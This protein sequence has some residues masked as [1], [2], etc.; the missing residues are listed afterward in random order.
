MKRAG[1]DPEL[2]R[3]ASGGVN[4]FRMT[5]GQG[6]IFLVADKEHGKRADGDRFLRRNFRNGKSR[7]F[8]VAIEQRPRP[9]SEESFAEPRIFSQT[10]VIVGSFAQIGEGSFGNDGLNARVEI[11]R[12]S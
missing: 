10:G 8:F 4:H 7:E 6:D 9:G 2:F 12:A 5:T 1:D 11:G 3:T